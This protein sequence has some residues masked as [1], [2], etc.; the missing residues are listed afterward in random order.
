MLTLNLLYIYIGFIQALEFQT[1]PSNTSISDG[2]A[3][4][5][6]DCSVNDGSDVTWYKDDTAITEDFSKYT[7][8]SAGLRIRPVVTSDA[9]KYY[10]KAADGKKSKVALLSVECKYTV[11]CILP[12]ASLCPTQGF[13][14]QNNSSA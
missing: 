5:V 10:C 7:F 6:L 13:Q 4:V 3:S 2:S 9:G 12:L 8:T 1:Q 11:Y 14:T